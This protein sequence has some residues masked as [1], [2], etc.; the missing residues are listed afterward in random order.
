MLRARYNILH[1]FRVLSKWLQHPQLRVRSLLLVTIYVVAGLAL[2]KVSSVFDTA[3]KITPWDPSSSL[4][5]VLLL[6]FGLR[7]T[8]ALVIVPILD[9]LVVNP[10][11]I[12]PV[13]VFLFTL[14]FLLGYGGAS[15]LLLHKLH[16]DPRLRRFRDVFWFTVVA[17]F[18]VP[19]VVSIFITTTLAAGGTISWSL[20]VSRL[21]HEWAGEATGIAILAPPL[22][23][24]LRAA[25]W[26]GSHVALD[27][28]ALPINLSCPQG[29]KA[30]KWG[31]EV[32]ALVFITWASYSIPSGKHLNYTYFVFLP[33]IW[34]AVRYGFERSALAILLINITAVIVVH[35]KLEE[36]DPLALQF[37]LMTLSHTGL[38][39]GAV[40][41]ERQQSLEQLLYDAYHDSLT[42]LHNRAWFIYKLEQTIAR[43]HQEKD[44]LFAV[45]FLDLDRFKV[46]NDSLGHATGNQLLSA[47]AHRLKAGVRTKDT[48]A[49]LGGDEFTILLEDIQDVR[50]ATYIAE[51]LTQE[52]A[53]SFNVNGHEVFITACIGIVISSSDARPEDLL[54]D[55][56]I[57]M[58][59]AKAKGRAG[60]AVFDRAMHDTVV[61]LL[62]L[63]ND[64]RRAVEKIENEP[65]TQFRLHYQP[66]VSLSTGRISGFEALSRWQHPIRGLVFPDQFIPDA[67]EN[68][69]IVLIGEWVLREACRQMHAWQL[70][71]PLSA[72]L[73]MAVNISGKQFLQPDLVK[74]IAQILQETGLNADSLKL[75]ITE[76]VVM[77]NS[78]EA[79][80]ML[81]QLKALGIQLSIDDF[82]TGYSSLNRLYSFPVN[83][84]K[85]DRCFVSKMGIEGENSEIVQVIV[86]LAQHLGMS[87]VAEGVETAAQLAKLRALKCE[88][89]QGYFFARPL[90]N[91]AAEKLLAA[92]PQW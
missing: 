76:S 75:E 30:L 42:G 33:L 66:I 82:G 38:L 4:H 14:W 47:I 83:T 3:E 79:S 50:E 62:Q 8:P 10:M 58:Y 73:T 41:T 84:L 60:Y 39:L 16:I 63:E 77:E 55:A 57:A 71:F 70:T 13:Y 78:E 9:N 52:L 64:L 91:Q 49:R 44:Y 92:A 21:L 87:V 74:Q 20:W 23:I 19:F 25:P 28:L 24:L 29:Q 67:E 86:M 31:A 5:F 26:T 27:R 61:R 43:F 34:I 59:R 1:C 89:G 90:T 15:A 54:R 45:L 51:R 17:A 48:I 11:H 7:Y 35:V 6:G 37:G 40:V 32:F 18:I 88:E 80:V 72:P 81:K 2:E 22:L 69:L 85:I 36:A 68:G 53:Q 46:V 56:D 65:Q 12:A